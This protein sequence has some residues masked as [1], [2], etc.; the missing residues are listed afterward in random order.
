MTKNIYEAE[1]N[2]MF[3]NSRYHNYQIEMQK[4]STWNETQNLIVWGENQEETMEEREILAR[5]Y[6]CFLWRWVT[7]DG[8][9]RKDLM[10]D[11]AYKTKP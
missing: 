1:Y 6:H 7:K 11:Q 2:H 5:A 9:R 4:I 8:K 10:R 3:M